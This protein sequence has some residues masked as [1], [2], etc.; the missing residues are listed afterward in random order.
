MTRSR[1]LFSCSKLQG[2]CLSNQHAQ[3]QGLNVPALPGRAEGPTWQHFSWVLHRRGAMPWHLQIICDCQVQAV[4]DKNG[5]WSPAWPIRGQGKLLG[6]FL[7][8]AAQHHW[9]TAPLGPS[10]AL[11]SAAQNVWDTALSVLL[12]STVQDTGDCVGVDPGQGHCGPAFDRIK[13]HSESYM[14]CFN[15]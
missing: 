9:Q 6:H 8:S 5:F 10:C 12:T 4:G 15:G 14:K 3:N 7:A 1:L 11:P 2:I 13:L